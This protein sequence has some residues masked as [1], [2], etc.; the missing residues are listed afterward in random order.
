M[1]A[2]CS[3]RVWASSGEQA[4][5][6]LPGLTRHPAQN[7]ATA[8]DAGPRVKPVPAKAGTRGDRSGGVPRP[9]RRQLYLCLCREWRSGFHDGIGRDQHLSRYGDERER[10][11]GPHPPSSFP[12]RREPRGHNPIRCPVALPP[13]GAGLRPD[14]RRGRRYMLAAPCPAN[15]FP[16]RSSRHISPQLWNN[17]KTCTLLSV[18]AA[19]APGSLPRTHAHEH[20]RTRRHKKHPACQHTPVRTFSFP[21]ILRERGDRARRL[22]RALLP[23]VQWRGHRRGL[24]GPAPECRPL[25]CAG[26]TGPDRGARRGSV[27]GKSVCPRHR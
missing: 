15:E 19:P 12:R 20:F 7:E 18:P 9:P 24:L 27:P 13:A 16:R 17:H 14:R 10:D 25:R 21:R 6:V 4:S 26:E 8:R 3:C 5:L 11:P 1:D 22:C 23:G 2:G